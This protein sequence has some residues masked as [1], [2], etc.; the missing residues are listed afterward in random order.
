[1][2]EE[3]RSPSPH[4]WI[5]LNDEEQNH[6]N[7]NTNNSQD[8]ILQTIRNLQEELQRRNS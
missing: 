5:E 2:V 1:M 4:V 3:G 7:N 6:T 8:K